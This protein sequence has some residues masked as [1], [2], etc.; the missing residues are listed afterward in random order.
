MKAPVDKLDGFCG[1]CRIRLDK[2]SE[3]HGVS[4]RFCSKYCSGIYEILYA[5]SEI[6]LLLRRNR[7]L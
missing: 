7:E 2:H 4:N 6:A 3:L 5:L 1:Q